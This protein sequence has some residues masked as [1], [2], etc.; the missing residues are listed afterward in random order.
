MSSHTRFLLCA[1]LGAL[2]PSLLAAEPSLQPPTPRAAIAV[3]AGTDS[4]HI[5]A[6]LAAA[7]ELAA[8][9]RVREAIRSLRAVAA[10]QRAAGDYPAEALR[11]LANLQYGEGLESDAARTLDE[12]A[13]AAQDFSDPPTRLRALFDAALIY[14]GLKLFD[15]EAERV[16]EVRQLLKS[17]A[18]DSAL[19]SD[20]SARMIGE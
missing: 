19:R 3:T 1:T 15:R 9:G 11:S 13:G 20:I 2:V 5:A 6:A 18:I 10:E 17:P 12:L 7:N 4:A 8:R 14:Q 16:R